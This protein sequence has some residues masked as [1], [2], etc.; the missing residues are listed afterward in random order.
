M[1]KLINQLHSI[2]R[3]FIDQ[4]HKNNFALLPGDKIKIYPKTIFNAVQNVSINGAN[5]P[6]I[7]ELKTNMTLLDLILEAGG[8]DNSIHRYRIEIA[9]INPLNKQLDNYA[10][11]I[12]FNFNSKL[13][14]LYK[15]KPG[16]QQNEKSSDFSSFSL[17]PFDLVSIR[18]DPYFSSQRKVIMQ[19]EILYPGQYTI[20]NSNE[21]ITDIIQ[22]AGGCY[23]M[24]IQMLLSISAM[25]RR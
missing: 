17:K 19:G 7:Y 6:G 13:E 22:R 12:V 25:E 15:D 16:I 9:R 3:C 10:K 11:V 24:L 21:K 23:L 2:W 5:K 1:I 8:V 18:P 4:N 20:L 14:I